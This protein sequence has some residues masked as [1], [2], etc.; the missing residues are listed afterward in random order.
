MVRR[1]DPRDRAT[2]PGAWPTRMERD[3]MAEI[4]RVALEWVRSIL[5]GR[6]TPSRHSRPAAPPVAPPA[7][8]ARLTPDV[9][10]ARLVVARRH[11][12]ARRVRRVPLAQ[13]TAQWF[14]PA[15]WEAPLT[16]VRPYVLAS[17]GEEWRTAP[18]GTRPCSW[19]A[20]L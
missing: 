9:P 15:P 16:V 7:L 13:P 1:K 18:A 17:L 10:G 6:R 19:G 20:A 8:P 14:P 11:R 5:W 3:D 2:G 4:I 12:E